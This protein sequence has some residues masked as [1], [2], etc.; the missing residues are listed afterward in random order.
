[1]DTAD[2]SA[3]KAPIEVTAEDL[4]DEEWGP[5]KEKSKKGKGGKGKKGQTKTDKEEPPRKHDLSVRSSYSY[6][7]IYSF[8]CSGDGC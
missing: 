8:R 7:M 6:R 3:N 1:L 5:V 4:A 2:A